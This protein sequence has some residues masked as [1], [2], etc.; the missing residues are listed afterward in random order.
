MSELIRVVGGVALR[1]Q[2]VF[3]AKRKPG[4]PHGGLWEF[5]GGKVEPG[6]SDAAALRRELAEELGAE[7][8]VGALVAVGRD[9]RVELWCYRVQ[10]P[11][12]FQPTEAQEHGWFTRAQIQALPTPP[13]DRPA[14]EALTT[15]LNGL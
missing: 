14:I 11:E 5:P 13:A 8:D 10:L 7:V 15:L 6:E 4:G 2:R 1:D 12:V 9:E 3:L